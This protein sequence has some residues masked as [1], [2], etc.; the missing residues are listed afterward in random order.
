MA[1]WA[2]CLRSLVALVAGLGGDGR[3]RARAAS[4]HCCVYADCA[5]LSCV[6]ASVTWAVAASIWCCNPGLVVGV[7]PQRLSSRLPGP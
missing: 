6:C 1:I 5:P 7:S 3:P 2:T 4:R